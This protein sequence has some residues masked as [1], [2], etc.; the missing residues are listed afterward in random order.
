[1]QDQ[2]HGRVQTMKRY[3]VSLEFSDCIARTDLVADFLQPRSYVSLVD[4]QMPL[5][6]VDARLKTDASKSELP[7]SWSETAL[8]SKAQCVLEGCWTLV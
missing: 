5:R 2:S 3:L 8:A 6:D 4:G 1:M 7:A